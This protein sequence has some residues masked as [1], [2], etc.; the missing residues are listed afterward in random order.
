MRNAANTD[1]STKRNMV[2]PPGCGLA[3]GRAEKPVGVGPA[4]WSEAGRPPR[5]LDR[6]RRFDS[7]RLYGG[8]RP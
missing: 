5:P 7:T 4:G 2:S 6:S 1:A 8:G 3:A